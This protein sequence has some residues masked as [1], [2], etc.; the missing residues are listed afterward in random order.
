MT[1]AI[2][3]SVRRTR[4]ASG[5]VSLAGLFIAVRERN[6]SERGDLGVILHAGV[7]TDERLLC[8]ARGE[9]NMYY[10]PSRFVS[11]TTTSGAA[12]K[13]KTVSSYCDRCEL[14]RGQT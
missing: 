6:K 1:R 13:R 10:V 5:C 8:S 9:R 2:L 7:R 4:R 12:T 14:L 11:V 3:S